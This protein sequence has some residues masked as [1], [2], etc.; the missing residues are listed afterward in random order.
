MAFDFNLWAKFPNRRLNRRVHIAVSLM[1]IRDSK[2]V[3]A[4]EREVLAYAVKYIQALEFEV[5]Q[6]QSKVD[7]P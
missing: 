3:S 5:S 7:L 6:L 4:N 1:D 2:D